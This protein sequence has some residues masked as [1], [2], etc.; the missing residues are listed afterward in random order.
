MEPSKA[1]WYAVPLRMSCDNCHA[2]ARY[3]VFNRYN[4]SQGRLCAR[5]AKRKLEESDRKKEQR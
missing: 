5:C 4:A 2:H 3:E 1:G